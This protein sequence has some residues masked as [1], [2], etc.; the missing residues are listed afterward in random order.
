MTLT[1][2]IE[3]ERLLLLTATPDMLAAELSDRSLLSRLIGAA[4]PDNWPPETLRDALPFFL[5]KVRAKPEQAGWWFWYWLRKS[6][7]GEPSILIGS[8]GFKGPMDDT[9]TVEIGYSVLPRFYRQ[10]FATE[11]A[12]ALIEWAFEQ[13]AL[14]GVIA[15]VEPANDASIGTLRKLGFELVGEGTEPGTIKY[16]ISRGK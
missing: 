4:V 6:V 11:G 3:S 10:G 5:D 2:I 12:R 9:G 13:T 1:T 7:N 8:G 14:R 15:H 16:Q